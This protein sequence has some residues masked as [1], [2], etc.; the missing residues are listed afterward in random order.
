[1]RRSDS[2]ELVVSSSPH[3]WA[4]I[5]TNTIMRDVLIALAPAT[6][7]AVYFFGLQAGAVIAV[8]VLVAIATEAGCQKWMGKPVTISDGSAAITGLLLAFNLPPTVPVWL[9]VIG[10]V[11]AIAIAKQA[12]GGLGRNFVNPAL[13]ARAFLLAAWPAAMTNW[14]K[15]FDAVTTATPLALLPRPFG[16]APEAVGALPSY[17]DLFLGNVGGSLGETSALLL[18][19]G[20]A[21]LLWR[22]IIDWRI[23]LGFLGTIAVMAWVF[24]GKGLFHGDPLYHVLAGGAI[25]GAFFMATD[26][27][28]TPITPKGRWIFGI[29]CG[30]ITML[31]R[32]FGGYP[33]GVSYSILIMNV[34]AP[35]LDRF[36]VPVPFGGVK[37]SA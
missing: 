29:A 12:F 27:V 36:T 2:G 1:M 3:R 18:L 37:R 13:A 33:E 34:V 15:P 14:A 22:R 21:Y 24:G 5:T 8:S 11:F 7:G 30:V 28:T 35:L 17:M 20:A 26:Y 23:P 16:P 25:L 19:L 6:L 10:S 4:G 9:P 31:V 32:L